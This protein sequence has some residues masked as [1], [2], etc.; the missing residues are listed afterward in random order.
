MAKT[1][2]H[3][4]YVEGWISL[5]NVD[6][7]GEYVPVEEWRLENH[8]KNPVALSNHDDRVIV[9]KFE[10]PNGNYTVEKRKNGLWGRCYFDMGSEA[11][12]EEYRLYKSGMKRGFSPKFN[13]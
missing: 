8:R 6:R 5:P 7:S 12:R 11:G 4:H 10:D 13:A 3:H 2:E 1:Q 9:G